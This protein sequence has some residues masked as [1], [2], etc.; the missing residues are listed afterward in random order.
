MPTL[1]KLGSLRILF[2]LLLVGFIPLGSL[3]ASPEAEEDSWPRLKIERDGWE[4]VIALP[5]ANAYY[6]GRRFA[7]SAFVYEATDQGFVFFGTWR[8]PH[9][10]GTSDDV[11]GDAGEFGIRQTVN[12]ETAPIGGEFLKIGVGH[13]RRPCEKPYSFSIDYEMVE[14]GQWTV[15]HGDYWVETRQQVPVRDGWGYNYSKRIEIEDRGTFRTTY[16]LKNTGSKSISTDFYAHNFV[17]FNREK[18]STGDTVVILADAVPLREP[19][20][21]EPRRFRFNGPAQLNRGYHTVFPLPEKLSGEGIVRVEHGASGATVTISSTAVPYKIEV[22]AIDKALCPEPFVQ[23]EL[24]P[25]ES[26]SWSDTYVLTPPQ[27]QP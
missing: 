26:M 10:R 1:F 7:H 17:V 15:E 14:A 25:G 16:H 8:D 18:V 19:A 27:R 13:L 4:F 3:S 9:K 22:Y 20:V 12:F 11:T 24:A 23:V 21:I 2:P 6:H 5:G